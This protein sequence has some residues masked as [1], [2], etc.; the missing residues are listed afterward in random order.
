VTEMSG[1]KCPDRTVRIFCGRACDGR[2]DI[3]SITL[4]TRVA[5]PSRHLDVTA[6]LL[7]L[8]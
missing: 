1:D 3:L 6:H 2:G 7:L 5:P 8:Q 4:S